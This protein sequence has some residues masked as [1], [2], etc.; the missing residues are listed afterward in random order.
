M[1][2]KQAITEKV[3]SLIT[4]AVSQGYS[5]SKLN[6]LVDPLLTQVNSFY[7]LDLSGLIE[8][9]IKALTHAQI[10]TGIIYKDGYTAPYSLA[11]APAGYDD[12]TT[13]FDFETELMATSNADFVNSITTETDATTQ[14]TSYTSTLVD[15]WVSDC[16]AAV[17]NVPSELKAIS[18]FANSLGLSNSLQQLLEPVDIESVP[19]LLDIADNIYNDRKYLLLIDTLDL[20]I[21]VPSNCRSE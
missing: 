7:N 4:Y 18:A 9:C 17:S 11:G 12:I 3:N 15:S 5:E 20:G 2:N 10:R 8:T 16:T 14:T 1:N 21:Y 6:T 19:K 13:V